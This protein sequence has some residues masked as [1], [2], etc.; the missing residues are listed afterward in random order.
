MPDT[1]SMLGTS[2]IEYELEITRST[3]GECHRI[4]KRFREFNEFYNSLVANDLI[5]N[6]QELVFPSKG[7]GFGEAVDVNSPYVQKRKVDLQVR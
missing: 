7:V 3:D 2:H 6:D 5:M 1:D 4:V